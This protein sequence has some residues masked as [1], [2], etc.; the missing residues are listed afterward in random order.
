MINTADLECR[1][2]HATTVNTCIGFHASVFG[3]LVITP[4]HLYDFLKV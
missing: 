3:Y 2:N 4:V 1:L